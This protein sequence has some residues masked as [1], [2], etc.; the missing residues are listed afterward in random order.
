[1]SSQALY[2]QASGSFQPL[3]LEKELHLLRTDGPEF[4]QTQAYVLPLIRTALARYTLSEEQEERLVDALMEDVPLAAAR[5][6]EV[7]TRTDAYS[8]ATYFTWYVGQR[9]NALPDKQRRGDAEAR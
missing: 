6:L 5:F 7:P 1:M 9:I 2:D 8:F 3:D 4:R